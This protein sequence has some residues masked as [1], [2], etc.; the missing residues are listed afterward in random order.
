MGFGSLGETARG[1][2]KSRKTMRIRTGAGQVEIPFDLNLSKKDMRRLSAAGKYGIK[3]ALSRVAKFALLPARDTA[4]KLS[5]KGI[6]GEERKNVRGL[7]GVGTTYAVGKGKRRKVQAYRRGIR[8]AGAYSMSAR[9]QGD[10]VTLLFSVKRKASYYNFVA[11]FW[12]HGWK[13]KGVKKRGNQFMTNSVTRNLPEIK[14][15][16]AKAV[17]KAVE[18]APANLTAAKLREIS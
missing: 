15:R 18:I 11:N 2:A 13:A 5:Q 14:E 4:R 12:E 1:Y 7:R 8:K 16:Y 10:K 9:S 17:A 3:N 6:R